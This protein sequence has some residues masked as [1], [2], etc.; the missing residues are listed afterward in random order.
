MVQALDILTARDNAVGGD[1]FWA[2]T[3]KRL[4]ALRT[5]TDLTDTPYLL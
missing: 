3:A 4:A 2:I 1:R 5:T